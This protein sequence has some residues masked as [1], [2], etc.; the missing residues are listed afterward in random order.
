M[1]LISDINEIK[2]LFTQP[3]VTL[4][5]FA[6]KLQEKSFDIHYKQTVVTPKG[7]KKRAVQNDWTCTYTFIWPE[8][9]KFERYY[10]LSR[11]YFIIFL[12]NGNISYEFCYLFLLC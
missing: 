7:G 6:S 10:D 8:K 12:L 4:N 2:E 5:E 1:N 11:K 3:R 9:I